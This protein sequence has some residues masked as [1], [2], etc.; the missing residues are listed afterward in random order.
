MSYQGGPGSD[1]STDV[2][3]ILSAQAGMGSGSGSSSSHGSGVV[4]KGPA[5]T[6]QASAAAAA[7]AVAAAL[8]P[9]S[10]FSSPGSNLSAGS[11]P[12]AGAVSSQ[13]QALAAGSAGGAYHPVLLALAGRSRASADTGTL[14]EYFAL[15]AE[16]AGMGMGK[17]DQ[18]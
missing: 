10:Q 15:A 5:R 17:C 4:H 11:A 9:T 18:S 3:L 8:S 16:R 12:S 14:V 13:H 1:S 2:F 7:A 6:A